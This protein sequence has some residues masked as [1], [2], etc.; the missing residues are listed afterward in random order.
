MTQ[1]HPEPSPTTLVVRYQDPA[2][3]L[4]LSSRPNPNRHGRTCSSPLI[5][6][7]KQNT[8]YK[9][10]IICSHTFASKLSMQYARFTETISATRLPSHSPT[11][12]SPSPKHPGPSPWYLQK[13]PGP[14]AHPS[15]SPTYPSFFSISC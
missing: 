5:H 6:T 15:L 8:L 11:Y 2:S 4:N 1:H 3:S 12:P 14:S 7:T 13:Y 9:S 10:T